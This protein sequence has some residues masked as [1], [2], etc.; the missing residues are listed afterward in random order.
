MSAMI[1]V[2]GSAR[3][4]RCEECGANVFTRHAGHRFECNGCSAMYRGDDSYT[5]R[6]ESTGAANKKDAR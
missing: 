3:S 1:Y 2:A 5:P 4:F 6:R